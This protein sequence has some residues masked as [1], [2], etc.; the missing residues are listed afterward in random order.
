MLGSNFTDKRG[1]TDTKKAK[2][3]Y[4]KQRAAKSGKSLLEY[5]AEF[6]FTPNEALLRQGENIFDAIAISDRLTQ[7]RVH[8][9]GIKPRRVALL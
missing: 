9:M 1:V 6:C 5:C 4:E 3:Y 2:E 8:K 7:I